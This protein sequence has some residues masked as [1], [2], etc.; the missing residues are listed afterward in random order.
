MPRNQPSR[1]KIAW[2]IIHELHENTD[3]RCARS[4]VLELQCG[5][6]WRA[7]LRGV[8][9]DSTACQRR[10]LF[11]V[12]RTASEAEN[13]RGRARTAIPSTE[14]EAASGQ[15]REGVRVRAESGIG[16]FFGIE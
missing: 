16:A 6:G 15:F 1:Q 3:R 4:S 13:R 9:Q 12:F 11:R 5:C 14:L 10:G 7:F 2:E 8:R